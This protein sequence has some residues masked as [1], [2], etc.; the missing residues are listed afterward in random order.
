MM[1]GARQQPADRKVEPIGLEGQH[2]WVAH[3]RGTEALA[4][5]GHVTTGGHSGQALCPI[6]A[7]H[8]DQEEIATAEVPVRELAIIGHSCGGLLARSAR[9]MAHPQAI[10]GRNARDAWCSWGRRTMRKKNREWLAA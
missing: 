10:A 3:A 7:C 5:Y 4:L 6:E 1:S 8:A 2:R 9:S